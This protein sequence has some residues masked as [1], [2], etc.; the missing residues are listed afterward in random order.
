MAVRLWSSGHSTSSRRQVSWVISGYLPCDHA[1]LLAPPSSDL[2]RRVREVCQRSGDVR[3]FI[4]ILHGLQK[5]SHAHS[6]MVMLVTP[7]NCSKK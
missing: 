1:P 7:T 5:V 2:V 3:F 6:M 4:P